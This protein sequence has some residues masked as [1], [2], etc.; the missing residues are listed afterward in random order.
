MPYSTAPKIYSLLPEPL[1]AQFVSTFLGRLVV[2]KSRPTDNYG[3][4]IKVDLKA[5]VP[6][7]YDEPASFT[8][9]TKVMQV[10]KETE[11]QLTLAKLLEVF[12]QHTLEN[13]ETVETP[14]F[15][16][17]R[18]SRIPQKFES[19]KN[20]N[21]YAKEIKDLSKY[22]QAGQHLCLVTGLLTCSNHKTTQYSEDISSTGGRAGIPS[23]ALQAAGAPPGM[24]MNIAARGGGLEHTAG[25]ARGVGE[26]VLAV[27]YHEI[28]YKKQ[29]GSKWFT[30]RCFPWRANNNTT[31]ELVPIIGKLATGNLDGFFRGDQALGEGS[32]A[33][34]VGHLAD[35]DDVYNFQLCLEESS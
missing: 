25:S 32:T 35:D 12:R 28:N 33:I 10:T 27:S 8:D 31:L 11:A 6:D 21:A 20:D 16:R 9:V 23:E 18:M 2:D 13:G 19:L 5:I 24:E 29:Q 17:Y 4:D 3:P 22:L 7:L 15:R 1:S 26:M 34:P 14:L 30:R